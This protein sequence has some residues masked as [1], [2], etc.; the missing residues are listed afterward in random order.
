MGSRV[1]MHMDLDYFYAQCEEKRSPHLKNRPVVVCMYSGRTEDSG[2]VA[3]ANYLARKHGVKSGMPI[4]FAMRTLKDADAAFLPVDDEYYDEVSSRVMQILKAHADKFQQESIDEAYLEVTK[5]TK[6]DF[7]R[8][9]D[10]AVTVKAEILEKE[11]LTCSTGIG[12][13]KV[14]AKIASDYQKPDGLTVVRP[15]EATKFLFPLDVERLL[16]VGKKTQKALNDIGVKTLEDL[17]KTDVQ[18]LINLFGKKL[19]VYL[20]NAANGMDE[21][22]V[23]EKGRPEQFSRIV[24]LKEDTRDTAVITK[25]LENLCHALHNRVSGEGYSFKTVGIIAV[26]EDL[27][28][29]TKSMTFEHS[30]GLQAFKGT[31]KELVEKLLDEHQDLK[32]RRIGVKA[33]GLMQEH[34]QRTLSDFLAA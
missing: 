10:H 29:H 20:H 32:L 31:A 18:V 3:T 11:G 33:S 21:E 23:E 4:A 15:E 26:M 12:P 16:G 1:V 34:G 17:A 19:G 14:I 7:E 8:A 13:N 25:D 30:V 22:P 28:Q 24:T 2:A 27:T 9:R 5:K 6:G